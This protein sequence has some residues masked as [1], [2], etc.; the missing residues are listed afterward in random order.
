M[1]LKALMAALIALAMI[2]VGFAAADAGLGTDDTDDMK[3]GHGMNMDKAIDAYFAFGMLDLDGDGIANCEDIDDD[4][5]GINDTL[6]EGPHDHDNDGIVDFED[7]DDDNDGI[8]DVD[9][10]YY[11][12]NDT[13]PERPEKPEGED[14]RPERD[15]ESKPEKG[16]ECPECGRGG[17]KGKGGPK[18]K[19]DLRRVMHKIDFNDLDS[20]GIANAEDV[21]DDGDGINDTLDEYPHDHDND[22]IPDYRDD[23]DDNDGILD[24]DDDEY[25][26]NTPKPK[27]RREKGDR[28]G[29]RPKPQE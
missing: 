10:D 18:G 2:G 15:N 21:D 7:D 14:E 22:D 19:F 9:D 23:D 26:G 25:V 4:G 24:E 3:K 29:R 6:D 8:L 5:D 20:D 12:G 13:L 16:E 1:A 28:D 27:E 17:G 11:V